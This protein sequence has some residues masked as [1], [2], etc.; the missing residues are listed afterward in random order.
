MERTFREIRQELRPVAPHAS[1]AEGATEPLQ[2]EQASTKP[3]GGSIT[4]QPGPASSAASHPVLRVL[5]QEGAE[6]PISKAEATAPSQLAP[7]AAAAP[8]ASAAPV[9]EEIALAGP[10]AAPPQQSVMANAAAA[11]AESGRASASITPVQDPTDRHVPVEVAAAA[12]PHQAAA[13]SRASI[14]L[15]P[16]DSQKRGASSNSTAGGVAEQI[17]TGM[18][19]YGNFSMYCKKMLLKAVLRSSSI[20]QGNQRMIGI[21]SGYSGKRMKAAICSH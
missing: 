17:P 20:I 16:E 7:P 13:P 2:R 8:Q 5:G 9:P 18:C 21:V 12:I 10:P 15:A 6:G 1:Q 4:A 3:A 19:L 11:T 14:S